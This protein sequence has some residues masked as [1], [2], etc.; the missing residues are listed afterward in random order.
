MGKGL[1]NGGR[2]G[3]AC[4]MFGSAMRRAD[5]VRLAT[6]VCAAAPVRGINAAISP[7]SMGAGSRA[8]VGCAPLASADRAAGSC[9]PPDLEAVAVRSGRRREGRDARLAA[10]AA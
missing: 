9:P 3:R 10:L 6:A 1:V 4:T 2:E 7:S 8:R 5:D